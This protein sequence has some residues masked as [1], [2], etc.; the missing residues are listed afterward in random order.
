MPKIA[1]LGEDALVALLTKGLGTGS[2]ILK[3]P[4]DDCAVLGSKRQKTPL[5]LFKTD[6]IVGG[7]HFLPDADPAKV[8]WKAMARAVSDIAAMGGYPVAALA[9]LVLHADTPIAFARGL[10]RGFRKA[11]RVFEFAVVGGET[12]STPAKGANIISV[13]ML[14]YVEPK[15]CILRSTAQAG[16][17]IY[18]TGQLGGSGDAGGHLTFQ[19]R[20][21]EARWLAG[22]F[23]P[24]AMMDLSDGLAKDLP[25]LADASSL[26]Y[27][28]DADAI[29]RKRSISIDRAVG[30]GEDYELLFTI[31]L[32]LAT[33][34]ESAWQKTFP[35]LKLSSV[36]TMLRDPN[37]RSEFCRQGWDHFSG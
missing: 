1:S 33:A 16:D 35:R 15:R 4:G 27:E 28:I 13:S 18:V 29:P 36:G 7:V 2:G 8:G 17:K 14:G 30:E 3:G 12:S 11:E 25:R 22:H 10:Y 9:T 21:E 20:L 31:R 19:P 23:K 34:L 24:T 6:C 26:G 5:T 32:N 37:E